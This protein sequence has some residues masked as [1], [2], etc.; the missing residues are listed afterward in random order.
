MHSRNQIPWGSFAA[1][2]RWQSPRNVGVTCGLS[3]VTLTTYLSKMFA[4][5][6]V[7]SLVLPFFVSQ[8][9][10]QSG[11]ELDVTSQG[12]SHATVLEDMA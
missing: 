7:L 10:G 1:I 9:L 6:K 3:N 12:T 4:R 5:N 11:I 2:K 8:A